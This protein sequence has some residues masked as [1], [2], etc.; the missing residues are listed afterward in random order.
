MQ[1]LRPSNDATLSLK[2]S[3]TLRSRYELVHIRFRSAA[4]TIGNTIHSIGSPFFN[5]ATNAQ[6]ARR[7]GRL[8]TAIVYAIPS[9]AGA[10]FLGWIH[11]ARDAGH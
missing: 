7:S 10:N 1:L 6:F 2:Y 5:F 9:R 4:D 11:P 3:Q 8:L